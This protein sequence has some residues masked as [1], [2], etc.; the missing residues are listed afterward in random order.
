MRWTPTNG[1][2]QLLTEF[3]EILN[4]L[5]RIL[6]GDVSSRELAADATMFPIL[7]GIGG[8]TALNLLQDATGGRLS[9]WPR[10]WAARTLAIIGDSNCSAAL[11]SAA[12]D[13][14]WRV[15]MNAVRATGLVSDTAAVDQVARLL[16]LDS[17]RRVREAVALAIGRNGSE[18]CFGVLQELVLD[19]DVSVRRAADRAISRLESR[20]GD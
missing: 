11:V 17:H 3:P 6:T 4:L 9:H 16:V 13:E 19:A 12:H 5:C 14:E 15:R 10:A 7:Y 20:I 1:A 8:N 2:A 18:F